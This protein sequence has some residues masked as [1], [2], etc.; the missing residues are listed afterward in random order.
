MK[1]SFKISEANKAAKKLENY[2]INFEQ[3]LNDTVLALA[4]LGMYVV[5]GI[6]STSSLDGTDEKSTTIVQVPTSIGH[7]YMITTTSHEILYF[8]FGSGIRNSSPA[9][10]KAGEHGMGPGTNSPKGKWD[11][12]KGWWYT[13]NDSNDKN[14]VYYQN[15]IPHAHTY[16][17]MATMPY[18]NAEKSIM[19]Q[20]INIVKEIW[21]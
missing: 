14:I 10:P 20:C 8:E 15:G 17:I 6:L 12:E 4:N 21:S 5:V 3:R 7:A 11:N 19:E 1:I 16:G 18:Y 9:N 13:P 2:R